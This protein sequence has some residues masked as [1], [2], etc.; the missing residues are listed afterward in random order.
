MIRYVNNDYKTKTF[1]IG[2]EVGMCYRLKE[3]YPER[4]RK[5]CLMRAKRC[6]D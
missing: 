3:I 4:G 1:V 6:S 2:T 5:L